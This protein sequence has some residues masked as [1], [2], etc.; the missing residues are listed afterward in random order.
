MNPSKPKRALIIAGP[1]GA[2]KTTFALQFLPRE[3]GVLNF[4]NADA[5]A[6]GLSPLDPGRAAVEAGRLMIRSIRNHVTRGEDF[7]F[8]TTLAGR[9]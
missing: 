2:G 1:N 9:R 5:I 4:V 8:E 6:A 3:A 7:A